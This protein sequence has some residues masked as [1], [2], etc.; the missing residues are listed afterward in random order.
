MGK[1]SILDRTSNHFLTQSFDYFDFCAVGSVIMDKVTFS[2]YDLFF[3]FF[4][5]WCS[6]LNRLFHCKTNRAPN[7]KLKIVMSSKKG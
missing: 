1:Y 4:R 6:A 3:T 7:C 5:L 2:K